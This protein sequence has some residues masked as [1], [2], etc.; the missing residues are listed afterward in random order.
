MLRVSRFRGLGFL[1]F[2]VKRCL[3]TTELG[4]SFL[5][6]GRLKRRPVGCL[7]SCFFGGSWAG[8]G[9]G[10]GVHTTTYDKVI[11]YNILHCT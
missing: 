1:G 3:G 5:R 6:L 10:G 11:Y 7:V 4:D 2:R 9:G 8:G